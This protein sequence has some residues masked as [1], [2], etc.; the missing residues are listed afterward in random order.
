MLVKRTFNKK[1]TP[2]TATKKSTKKTNTK[3]KATTKNHVSKSTKKTNTKKKAPHKL[4]TK[5]LTKASHIYGYY[6]DEKGK[7]TYAG[8]CSNNV[9]PA[10]VKP[11]AKLK[12]WWHD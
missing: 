10:K 6:K 3:K 1:A 2:K 12:K 9:E 11:V 8:A 5:K 4:I 7:L